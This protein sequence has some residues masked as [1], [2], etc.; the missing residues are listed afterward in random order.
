MGGKNLHN[1]PKKTASSLPRLI[2]NPAMAKVHQA[3]WLHSKKYFCIELLKKVS[4]PIWPACACCNLSKEWRR[5]A[6][7]FCRGEIAPIVL[8]HIFALFCT[9]SP[10]HQFTTAMYGGYSVIFNHSKTSPAHGMAGPL[11]IQ[12]IINLEKKCWSLSCGLVS[13]FFLLICG[14]K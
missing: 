14:Y 8:A 1:M 5:S 12:R 13:N 9:C 7:C 4:L 3:A 11:H 2:E 10:T 6:Y